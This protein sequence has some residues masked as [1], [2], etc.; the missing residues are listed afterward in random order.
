MA[1][2]MCSNMLLSI[3]IFPSVLLP[4]N[5]SSFDQTAS[6]GGHGPPVGGWGDTS[7]PTER[8]PDG[9]G[10]PLLSDDEWLTA[11]AEVTEGHGK[12]RKQW[13]F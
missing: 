5:N 10:S 2:A 8:R 3:S 11:D 12:K 13:G 4:P 9:N 6:D 7:G 1:T